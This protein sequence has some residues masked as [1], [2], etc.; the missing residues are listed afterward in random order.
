MILQLLFLHI[1]A[2]NACGRFFFV[3]DKN[4]ALFGHVIKNLTTYGQKPCLLECLDTPQCISI[5]KHENEA[6]KVTCELSKSSKE[7]SP[8]DFKPR[9]GF[10]HLQTI[11][12]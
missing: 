11:V 6:G 4:F 7:A 12:S 9:P 5:N 1:S 10:V 8:D 2:V 3:G